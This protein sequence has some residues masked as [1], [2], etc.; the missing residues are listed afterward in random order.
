[1]YSNKGKYLI[2]FEFRQIFATL[3]GVRLQIEI[4]FDMDIDQNFCR[5]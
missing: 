3:N 1:M 4:A 2:W 5:G